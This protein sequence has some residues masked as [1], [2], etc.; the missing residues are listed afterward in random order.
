M[1]SVGIWSPPWSW[2]T[3]NAVT[4]NRVLLQNPE[5]YPSVNAVFSSKISLQD[6]TIEDVHYPGRSA[7]CVREIVPARMDRLIHGWAGAETLAR[8]FSPVSP[9]VLP[10]AIVSAA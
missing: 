9:I 4:D 2:G 1:V 8:L 10:A 5:E 6:R 7:S 3:S